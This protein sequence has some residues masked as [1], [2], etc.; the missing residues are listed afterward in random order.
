MT[1]I[2]DPDQWAS[3]L[4]AK[5]GHNR[6]QLDQD[7]PSDRKRRVVMT[8]VQSKWDTNTS[9][10]RIDSRSASFSYV[11]STLVI[12]KAKGLSEIL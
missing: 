1:D 10:S 7:Y 5:A 4:F 12:S 8:G 2:A 11:Q 9:T 3:S 6:V